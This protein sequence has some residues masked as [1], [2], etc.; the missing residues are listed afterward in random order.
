M[1]LNFAYTEFVKSTLYVC[2]CVCV[3]CVCMCVCVDVQL[4]K[5]ILL[6]SEWLIQCHL[7]PF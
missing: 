7:D 5:C 2:V 3:L 1:F 4:L 6:L